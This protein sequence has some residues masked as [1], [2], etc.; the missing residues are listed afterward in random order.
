MLMLSHHKSFRCKRGCCLICSPNDD[1]KRFLAKLALTLGVSDHNIV[2][3]YEDPLYYI[4]KESELPIDIDPMKA[5]LSDSLERRTIAK[6]LSGGLNN[7][8]GYV[9]PLNFGTT[10]WVTSA[11]ELRRG[12]LYLSAGNSPL[13]L[14]LPLASLVE[15]PHTEL[16][17]RFE[18]DLFA[19]Y[20]NLGEYAENAKKRCE[21]ADAAVLETP[22]VN[23]FVRTALCTEVRDGKLYVF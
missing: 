7:P 16:A 13:G 8:V 5:D 23:T 19:S 6:V 3:A 15:K 18:P 10:R 1:A 9:L 2:E 14:R 11:W 17:L 21:K 12:Y 4:I 22:V 20:P